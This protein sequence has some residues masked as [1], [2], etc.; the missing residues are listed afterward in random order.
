MRTDEDPERH[1]SATIKDEKA[2]T[3]LRKEQDKKSIDAMRLAVISG[4]L[5][6]VYVYFD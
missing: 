5:E 3:G 4:D 6:R 1:L 2:L